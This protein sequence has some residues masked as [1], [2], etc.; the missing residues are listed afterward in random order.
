MGK[1][2]LKALLDTFFGRSLRDAVATHLTGNASR[3]SETELREIA[4]LIEAAQ[5]QKAGGK[6]S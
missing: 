4:Q 6:K 3:L 5:K 1:K 2:A